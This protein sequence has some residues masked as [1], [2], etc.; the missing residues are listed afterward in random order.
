MLTPPIFKL[1]PNND[2]YRTIRSITITRNINKKI[3]YCRWQKHIIPVTVITV[4]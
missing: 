2:R 1:L 3:G 4:F